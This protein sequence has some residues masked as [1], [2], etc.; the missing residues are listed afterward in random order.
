[1]RART[2][3]RKKSRDLLL[4]L[5][6]QPLRPAGLSTLG[7]TP[8]PEPS[9]FPGSFPSPEQPVQEKEECHQCERED[10]QECLAQEPVAATVFRESF[11]RLNGSAP[12][13]LEGPRGILHR[14]IFLV[15]FVG[16]C[17]PQEPVED[18]DVPCL[19]GGLSPPPSPRP[20]TSRLRLGQ[21]PGTL[22]VDSGPEIMKLMN[23]LP[24]EMGV[25]ILLPFE[26]R[27]TCGIPG[28]PRFVSSPVV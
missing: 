21:S 16:S 18:Q 20:P 9:S 11:V 27:P 26:R 14:P 3:K 15:V 12:L 8:W 17:L 25:P 23:E 4:T 1:V 6:G 28:N 24:A 22:P 13:V 5:F 7:D 2:G 10:Q 19:L